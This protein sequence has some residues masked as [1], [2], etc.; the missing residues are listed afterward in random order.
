[1]PSL[2]YFLRKNPLLRWFSAGGNPFSARAR[3]LFRDR[4]IDE[5]AAI[6]SERQD[7]VARILEVKKANPDQIPD[8]AVVEYIMTIMLAG[9]DT[10]SITLRSIV[11]YL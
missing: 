8:H 10:V 7:F 11:Y 5:G 9:S 2:D 3:T 6:G 4:M 1:M